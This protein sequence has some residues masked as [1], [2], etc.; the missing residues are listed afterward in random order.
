M[1]I[2]GLGA[3][4]S[5]G[6]NLLTSLAEKEWVHQSRWWLTALVLVGFLAPVVSRHRRREWRPVFRAVA[7]ADTGEGAMDVVAVTRSGRVL[8]ASYHEHG[9]WSEWLDLDA[10]TAAWDVTAVVPTLGSLEC[11]VVD[12]RGT[13]HILR[14]DR[15]QWSRWRVVKPRGAVDGRPMRIASASVKAG[16]REIFAVTDKGHLVHVW[17]WDNEDWSSWNNTGLKQCVDVAACSPKDDLIECFVVDRD[18][19]VRHRWFWWDQ[20]HEWENWGHPGSA[21]RAL[22][23]FRKATDLQEM[24]LVGKAGDLF[25]RWHAGGQTWSDWA[26]SPTPGDLVDV[27]AGTT[28]ADTLQCLALDTQGELW[29]T[30]FADPWQAWSEWKPVAERVH[31]ARR[32][33]QSQIAP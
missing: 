8:W 19:D 5:A 16:H 10:P 30:T 21:G 14:R 7:A 15:G 24:F 13:L 11:F 6:V 17:R 9:A 31:A 18:G 20:W 28:S 22:T 32:R 27:A 2:V 25:H 23:S 33:S 12:E 1:S 29:Q 4:A 3:V 26:V